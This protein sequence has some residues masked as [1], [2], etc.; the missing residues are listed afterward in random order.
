MEVLDYCRSIET[1]LTAWKAKFYD[2][3]RKIDRLGTAEKERVLPNVEDLHIFL[4][5]LEDRIGQ[6][7]TECPTEWS[8][9]KSE[10]DNAHIDMRGKYEETMAYIGKA[11][12]V[13]IPG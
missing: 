10:I 3:S 12:P 13:S 7:K 4:T 9:I 2:M 1:E 11:A 6:L 5:E 8:P